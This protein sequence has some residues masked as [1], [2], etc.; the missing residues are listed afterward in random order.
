MAANMAGA[1]P[2][3]AG[4]AIGGAPGGGVLVVAPGAYSPASAVTVLARELPQ[5]P[6]NRLAHIHQAVQN[7]VAPMTTAHMKS[8]A[9]GLL[10]ISGHFFPDNFRV[11]GAMPEQLLIQHTV[12]VLHHAMPPALRFDFD[13][14]T[15]VDWVMFRG[16]I[17][18]AKANIAALA[19][20]R[21]G[22]GRG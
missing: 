6:L 7:L 4:A 11:S 17:L 14:E 20:H 19:V 8:L 12:A 15:S 22:G 5:E 3:A 2:G 9:R 21:P 18:D 10:G 13:W 16:F 1:G